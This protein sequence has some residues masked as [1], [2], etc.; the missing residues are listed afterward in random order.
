M[1]ILLTLLLSFLVTS[2][3]FSPSSEIPRRSL[4]VHRAYITDR[5]GA[6]QQDRS[7]RQERVGQLVISELSRIIHS[8]H[9]GKADYLDDDLR[10]RVS[11]V[12]ANVSPDLRQARISVSVRDSPDSDHDVDKRRAYSWLVESAKYLRHELAKKMSHMKFSSP[13]LHFVRVDVGAAVDVMDLID[14]ISTGDDTRK[15]DLLDIPSGVVNGVDFDM[16]FDDD[17]WDDED[18]WEDDDDVF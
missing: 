7:K 15:G 1:R 9:T 14:K 17:E 13:T 11:I 16:E 2:F 18:D 12:K 8:G 5:R 6:G 10:Q 3:A 4:S